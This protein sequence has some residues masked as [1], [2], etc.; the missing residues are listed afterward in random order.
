MIP[1]ETVAHFY[2]TH[3]AA[4]GL[5]GPD[6]TTGD[7]GHF[8]VF[9]RV[10]CNK[11][12]SYAR[13]DFYKISLILGKGKITYGNQEIEI[14]R[15]ALVFF[16]RNVPY[17][18]QAM[19]EEQSGYF[20]LF[21][22]QF[23]STINRSATVA[24]CPILRNDAIPVYFINEEQQEYL[25]SIFGKMQADIESSYVHKYDLMR[26]YVNVLAHEAMKMQPSEVNDVHVNGSAK[27]SSQFHE[28]LERQFP[29]E[30]PEHKLKL[31][32]AKDYAN[33][34]GVHVNHLNRALKE[35]TGKTTTEHIIDRVLAQSKVMLRHSNWSVAEIAFCLGF[36]YPAYF[37]NL[38]KKQ[39]GITPKSYRVHER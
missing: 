4:K 22:D 25:L 7:E 14:N 28:L 31:K 13:R 20:C 26:N 34:L 39:I 38:F 32:T 18:W 24:D 35:I 37:N 29:I 36:E 11:Y 1:N 9:S 10:F 16:N 30:S 5:K 27:L 2:E 17:S 19:S 23:L 21:T 12:T 6:K 3:P 33:R 8:N 15:N